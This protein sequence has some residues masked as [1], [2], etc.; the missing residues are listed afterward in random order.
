MKKAADQGA[1]IYT[2]TAPA[3]MKQWQ[4]TAPAVIQQ[5]IQDTGGKAKDVFAK[6]QAIAPP[7]RPTKQRLAG[8][9]RRWIPSGRCST[10][11]GASSSS[12]RLPPT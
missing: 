3:E 9:K 10:C 7:A 6:M 8:T 12:W 1:T 11:F 4:S 2:P 5:V